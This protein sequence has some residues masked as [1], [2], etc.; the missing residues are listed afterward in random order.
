MN[1]LGLEGQREVKHLSKLTKL[2]VG[3]GINAGHLSII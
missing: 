2:L 1:F 3:K